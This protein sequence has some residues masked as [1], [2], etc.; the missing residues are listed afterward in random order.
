MRDQELRVSGK[1]FDEWRAWVS[2]EVERIAAEAGVSLTLESLPDQDYYADWE[3]GTTPEAAASTY[4][5]A[6]GWPGEESP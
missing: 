6:A 3:A 2:R 5:R 4:L 1:N